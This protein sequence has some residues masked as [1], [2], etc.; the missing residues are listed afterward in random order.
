MEPNVVETTIQLP[1]ID[2]RRIPGPESIARYTLPNG[3]VVLVRENFLSPSVVISGY[4]PV[5]ALADPPQKSGMANLTATALMRGTETRSFR[6]I[7]ESIESIGARLSISSSTHTTSFQGKSLAEDLEVLLRLSGEV[8]RSPTFPEDEV[9]RLKGQILTAF[10]IRD[11]DTGARAQMAFDE[12]LYGD[13]PYSIQPDGYPETINPLTSIDIKDFHAS[14]YGPDGMVISIVGAIKNDDALRFVQDVFGDWSAEGQIRQPELPPVPRPKAASKIEVSLEGKQQSDI[15]LGTV[16]PSRYDD[17]YLT[18]VLANNILGRFGMY[19]RIGDSVRENAGLAYYSYS[20]ITGGLGPGPWQVIAGVNPVNI[21]KA[22]ELI[23]DEIR[24]I[25][26][27]RVSSSELLENQA[28]FIGR[29]P[30][31]L[32]SNE[33]VAG[34][35]LSLERYDL[36]MD[37]YQRYPDLIAS[38][39]REEIFTTAKRYLDADR[40]TIA[41]AGPDRGP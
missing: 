16:G 24:K 13:H 25:T 6:E 12:A 21:D 23:Q 27:R 17:D 1:K 41:I 8:L 32:E 5:G 31:Q 19:G 34:A 39:T 10:K 2:R 22:I 37:Y 33:G 35:L 3:I 29:L 40:L 15:V 20:V 11:Q 4:L 38:I 14:H 36:G 30:M 9:A 28:N 26:S 7:F 18:A